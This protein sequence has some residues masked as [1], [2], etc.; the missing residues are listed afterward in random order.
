MI[1]WDR[2]RAR[3]LARREVNPGFFFG[4]FIFGFSLFWMW[5]ASA[6]GAFAL[7]GLVPMSFALWLIS[8][9]LRAFLRAPKLA[10]GL[11]DRRALIVAPDEVKS[12]PLE[13]IAFVDTKSSNDGSGHVYFCNE[14]ATFGTSPFYHSGAMQKSGFLAI[15]KAEQVSATLLSLIETR[16]RVR[17]D[18][19]GSLRRADV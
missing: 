2:P 13:Q 18:P 19:A 8:A 11:S 17:P 5:G 14:P 7:F 4:F 16:R 10:F 1:W 3:L 6:A 12:Y 15:A 9:P